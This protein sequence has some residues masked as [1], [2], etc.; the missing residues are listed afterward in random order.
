MELLKYVY[1]YAQKSIVKAGNNKFQDLIND[2]RIY[3]FHVLV[4]RAGFAFWLPHFLFVASLL[5][6]YILNSFSYLSPI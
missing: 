4:L 1:F 2:P 5:L 3:S 6:S